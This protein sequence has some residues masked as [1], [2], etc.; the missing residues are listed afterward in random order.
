MAAGH[1]ISSKEVIDEPHSHLD[2]DIFN[3]FD[4]KERPRCGAVK[5]NFFL[6]QLQRGK[7]AA[8]RGRVFID[9]ERP[10]PREEKSNG[11]APSKESM[12][13]YQKRQCVLKLIEMEDRKVER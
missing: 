1:H 6:F 7:N 2:T 4:S 9:E 10:Q 13:S 12:G 5:E 11:P 3:E 8:E